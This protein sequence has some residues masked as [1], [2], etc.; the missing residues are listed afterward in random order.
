MSKAKPVRLPNDR[1]WEKKGDAHQHFKDMLARYPVGER[2]MDKQDESDLTALLQVYDS[3]VPSGA[4][5]KSGNGVAFFSKQTNRGEGYSTDG[6][7]VHR[8]DGTQIDFSY[9]DALTVAANLP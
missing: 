9:P 1:F 4:P 2:I 3:A 7:H 6:F 8:K 5:T